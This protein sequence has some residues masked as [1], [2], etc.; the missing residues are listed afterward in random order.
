MQPGSRVSDPSRCNDANSS[1]FS[2]TAVTSPPPTSAHRETLRPRESLGV[3][4]APC[5][6]LSGHRIQRLH[7][8]SSAGAREDRNSRS[9]GICG[10][11]EGGAG[12]ARLPVR[13]RRTSPL[14]K[15]DR[16]QASTACPT[17]GSLVMERGHPKFRSVGA[18]YPSWIDLKSILLR[19]HSPRPAFP[20]LSI[21]CGYRWGD[22]QISSLRDSPSG[23][24]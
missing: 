11:P 21:C 22:R 1:P 7:I 6:S 18:T 14:P 16:V 23:Q 12:G 3:P 8:A 19:S 24:S 20:A 9:R 13:P 15:Q 5:R 17:P 10:E 4:A 2:R